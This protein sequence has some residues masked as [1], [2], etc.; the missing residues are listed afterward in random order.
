VP[1]FTLL[2]NMDLSNVM[3]AAIMPNGGHPFDAALQLQQAYPQRFVACLGFQNPDWTRQRPGFITALEEKLKTGGFKCLGEVL[4]LHY[5]IPERQAPHISILADAPMALQVLDLAARYRVPVTLHMEAEDE[6]VERLARVI[7]RK[8]EPVVIWAHAGRAPAST[9]DRFLTSYPNLYI[10]L[11]ALT[12]ILL[13]GREKNPIT[14]AGGTLTSE[15]RSLLIKFQDRVLTG[16]DAPFPDLWTEFRVVN[17]VQ[18]SRRLL[19][20]L[21]ME[22]AEKIAFGNA[23]RLLGLPF[24]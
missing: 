2:R 12:P 20:Q 9:V 5:A 6:T 16:S 4:L 8:Q 18:G 15:W 13:Y 10:D 1:V 17:F 23:A 21:P 22:V 7:E 14:D 24:P 3:T 11:A 19:R